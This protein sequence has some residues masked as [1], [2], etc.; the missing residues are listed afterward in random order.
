MQNNT[1]KSL[2]KAKN[3]LN[4]F[5]NTSRS[6]LRLVEAVPTMFISLV[7]ERL[8]GQSE[9]LCEFSYNC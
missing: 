6:P 5:I 1:K 8:Y 4:Y 7:T 2:E 9:L 3:A